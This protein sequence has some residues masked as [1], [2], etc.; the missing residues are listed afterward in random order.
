M[1]A[2]VRRDGALGAHDAKAIVASKL[3]GGSQIFVDLENP[4]AD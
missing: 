4:C 2:F 1:H 3:P